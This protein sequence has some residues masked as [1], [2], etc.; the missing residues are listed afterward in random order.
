[1]KRFLAYILLCLSVLFGTFA[2]FVP[3]IV[4]INASADYDNGQNFVYRISTKDNSDKND[5]DIE[6]GDAIDSVVSIFKSRLNSANISTYK[7]ETEGNNTIRLSFKAQSEINTAVAKYLNF[8]WNLEAMDYSGKILL[9]SDDFFKSGD[10][11]I[12]YSDSYPVIVMPLANAEDFKTKLY[13]NVKDASSSDEKTTSSI[14]TNSFKYQTMDDAA[15]TTSN[16]NYI[17]IVNNWDTTSYSMEKVI[18]NSDSA[19]TKELNAYIDRIDATKPE[20][21]YFD[22]DSTKTDAT[23]TK[24]K[25]TG[26]LTNAGSDL[27]LANKLANIVCAELNSTKIDYNLTLI[28]KDIINDA[29]NNTLPFIEKLIYRG[30]EYG[31]YQ[32]I[33]FSSLLIS[34]LVAYVVVSLFVILNY[35]LSGLT[36]IS[37]VPG[38]LLLTLFILNSFGAEFNIGMIIAL[39]AIAI[40]F[41]FSQLSYFKS[42][43]EELYKGRNLRKAN[44]EASKKTL[45]LQ[46][47]LSII[48]ILFGL[49]G[50]LIPNSIM[51]SV[52]AT[53]ILGGLL[54]LV[55][56][57]LLLRGMYYFLTNSS[58]VASHLNLL[59]IEQ[60]KIPN[61]A[62]DEKPTYFDG[63]NKKENKKISKFY[64]IGGAILLIASI[65]GIL[66]FQLST[67][68][69]YNSNSSNVIGSRVYLQFD[70]NENSDI[71]SVSDLETKVLDHLY[72]YDTTTNNRSEKNVGYSDVLMYT[73]SYKENY[74][75]NKETL[76]TIYYVIELSSI[77]SENSKVS[78]YVNSSYYLD[79]VSVEDALQYLISNYN[80]VPNFKDVT[81]NDVINV[82]DDTNNYYA[83]LFAVIGSLIASLYL[84]LRYGISRGLT[85]LLIIGGSLT[86]TIGIFV[87]TRGVF[88]SQISLGLI[89]LALFGY[90][91]LLTI[92]S[93][94]RNAFK[95]A[96]IDKNDLELRKNN[97]FYS[98]NLAFS[99]ILIIGSL[100][101][102]II[103]SFL[104]ATTFTT[105]F[106][107]L[108][109]IGILIVTASTKLLNVDVSYVLVKFFG[110]IKVRINANY[111][112]RK[113]K[114][115]KKKNIVDKGD[116]PEEA[117]FIGIND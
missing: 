10:A 110:N 103:I 63:F 15:E 27:A 39:I 116:G 90:A 48:S 67:G 102:F 109:I 19:D 35:N 65:V 54:N 49:V 58:F 17:Y 101:E 16:A 81:L 22:Y 41:L 9:E 11:Y 34:C 55:V 96:K 75:N 36:T 99:N 26:F 107:I 43:K 115:D 59:M 69:I 2:S 77:Y 76:K 50:Y 79:N 47:D 57:G 52:G 14:E 29:T 24:L 3:T 95:D 8:D 25:Y 40:I 94:E 68:N 23:F 86:I 85:S 61:L 80:S 46:I 30:G 28:N 106:I 111:Q 114:H 21:V 20:N 42:V 82:N 51:V 71:Q 31:S 70:Y 87:L 88:T 84:I 53:L 44:E 104:F 108:V 38:A 64:G 112:A 105:Y 1:V 60:K 66:S 117:T 83:M 18:T 73:Y 7:L 45:A 93:T 13:Q 5:G 62:N 33:I 98:M 100:S 97:S 12:D 6:S 72:V 92:F 56:N 37:L 78:A 32:S 91:L 74:A 89:I 113:S 4:S